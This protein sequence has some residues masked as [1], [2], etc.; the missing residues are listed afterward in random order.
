MP[1][2]AKDAKFAN[3]RSAIYSPPG[4]PSFSSNSLPGTP[5]V[6][7]P[8][9]VDPKGK[10]R[11]GGIQLVPP[12]KSVSRA[13]SMASLGSVASEMSGMSMNGT[14]LQP[15]SFRMG[16]YGSSSTIDSS[17]PATPTLSL[18]R[19]NSGNSTM[20]VTA[21]DELG[22]IA[23]ARPRPSYDKDRGLPLPQTVEAL[24]T[25]GELPQRRRS[26]VFELRVNDVR[27]EVMG[28]RSESTRRAATNCKTKVV[29]TECKTGADSDVTITEKSISVGPKKVDGSL[30]RGKGTIKR[31]WKRVL[32]TV[33]VKA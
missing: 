28:K 27:V 31:V 20:K 8:V 9:V 14:S 33:S 22:V 21:V 3:R 23:P 15:P 30:S 4:S 2:S 12:S 18:S 26:V 32:S 1:V 7:K 16:S 24:R 10:A 29:V 6:P 17:L 13:S 25:S 11:E 19:T 5:T